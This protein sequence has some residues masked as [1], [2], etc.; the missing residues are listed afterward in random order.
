MLPSHSFLFGH[1]LFVSTLTKSYPP[2]AHGSYAQIQIIDNWKEYFPQAKKI[3]PV[4]YLDLWPVMS[5][6]FIWVID[7]EACYQHA[8][9]TPLKRHKLVAW[10]LYP[11]TGGRDLMS[12]NEAS[13]RVW[14]NRLNPG[15]SPRTMMQN[16]PAIIAEFEVFANSLRTMSGRDG[17]WSG[18]FR[19]QKKIIAL[20]FD[21]IMKMV[22]LVC[23]LLFMVQLLIM[24]D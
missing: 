17:E 21:L 8:Q 20:T 13:H 5:Q 15:F 18:M 23:P 3:P 6:P 11:M 10:A 12:V 19:M 24:I 4:I 22:A 16:L 2:D 1:L 14:R 9:L 7:P